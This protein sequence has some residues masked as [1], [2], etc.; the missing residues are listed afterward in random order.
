ME[1]AEYIS[2]RSEILALEPCDVIAASGTHGEGVGEKP[3]DD[4]WD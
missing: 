1:K 2:P 3:S 4:D